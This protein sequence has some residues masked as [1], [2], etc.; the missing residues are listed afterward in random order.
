M[1]Q[2]PGD[3]VVDCRCSQCDYDTE[4]ECDQCL[5]MDQSP[6]G[7]SCSAEPGDQDQPAFEAAG[8]ILDLLVAVGV[9]RIGGSSG[10]P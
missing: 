4:F 6:D 1:E 10:V 2:H 3:D 8:E 7:E 5:R 9:G